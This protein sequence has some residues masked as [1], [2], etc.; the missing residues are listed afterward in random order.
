MRGSVL[1]TSLQQLVI[2]AD[3]LA[4]FPQLDKLL[5]GPFADVAHL[6]LQSVRHEALWGVTGKPLCNSGMRRL[7]RSEGRY[8]EAVM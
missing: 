4:D 8:G 7:L 5:Q 1:L 2:H 6:G 3:C